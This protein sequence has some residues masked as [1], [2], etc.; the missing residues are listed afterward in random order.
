MFLTLLEPKTSMKWEE[1]SPTVIQD[2]FPVRPGESGRIHYFDQ[3]M[4]ELHMSDRDSFVCEAI[5]FE[6]AKTKE[7]S[8]Y[9]WTTD[10]ISIG[11]ARDLSKLATW[12]WLSSIGIEF[13]RQSLE[14][15]AARGYLNIL[16]FLLANKIELSAQDRDNVLLSASFSGSVEVYKFLESLVYSLTKDSPRY[17]SEIAIKGAIQSGNIDLVEYLKYPGT[18]PD[19]LG[20][21]INSGKIEMV[22]YLV[23]KGIYLPTQ[24]S[25][26]NAALKGSLPI[27]QYLVEECHLDPDKS[28]GL[29]LEVALGG[30][31]GTM[32]GGDI[33][34][35]RYL[36][37]RS[38][39]P[40]IEGIEEHISKQ[41]RVLDSLKLIERTMGLPNS[42]TYSTLLT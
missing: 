28:Y 31:M 29:I 15:A 36:L 9:F 6:D 41:R 14:W 11:E 26:R 12:E 5:P 34:M 21:G 35:V 37:S 17:L 23:E 20:L 32:G 4:L 30:E 16:Q 10:I 40:Y 27:V 33:E 24:D 3:T 18:F 8:P 7:Q 19:N 25:L 42:R 13:T 22:R 38:K 1:V 39:F 2:S